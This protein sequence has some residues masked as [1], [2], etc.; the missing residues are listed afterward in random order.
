MLPGYRVVFRGKNSITIHGLVMGS[1][2]AFIFM[3]I[4]FTDRHHFWITDHLT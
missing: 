1:Y 2:M 4:L 3:V